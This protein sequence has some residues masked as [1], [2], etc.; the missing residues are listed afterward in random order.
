MILAQNAQIN[1]VFTQAAT[2]KVQMQH[3]PLLRKALF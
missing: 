1:N 2:E 3:G